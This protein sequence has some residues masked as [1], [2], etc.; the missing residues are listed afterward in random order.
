MYSHGKIL[1]TVSFVLLAVTLVA[2]S[3]LNTAYAD[4]GMSITANAVD[5]DTTINISGTTD[6]SNDVIIQVFAPNGNLVT[7]DQ[8]PV[9]DDKFDAEVKTGGNLWKQDGMYTITTKQGDA[10]VYN[11]SVQVEITSGMT[12]ETTASES[13]ITTDVST[14]QE[15]VGITESTAGL[16]ITADAIEGSTTIDVSGQTDTTINDVTLTVTSPNGNIVSIDQISPNVD[17]S[18]MVSITTGGPL[19][20]QDGM[21]TIT[22]RQGFGSLYQDSTQVEIVDG[23][24]I[25][26]FGTIAA[27]ILAV[28][29]VSIIVVS[30]KTR[31]SLVPRY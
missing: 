22:A 17:G 28:A 14:E 24:V 29:I 19:W 12:V 5:G 6:R 25:P 21:Y 31:L 30:T 26:E 18:F 10:L 2:A 3:G 16:S 9:I 7:I 13:S 11:L 15:I 20:K 27:M 1:S 8:V 4:R 23:A